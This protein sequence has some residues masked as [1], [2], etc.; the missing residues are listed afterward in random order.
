MLIESSENKYF[1]VKNTFRYQG[2]LVD[3]TIPLV[4]GILNVTPDSFFDGGRF[5]SIDKAVEHAADMLAE[6]A[7]IIDVGAYSTRPGAE[8]IT[9]DE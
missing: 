6:S 5:S 3:M 4:M 1:K 8:E 9:A 2:N 7:S